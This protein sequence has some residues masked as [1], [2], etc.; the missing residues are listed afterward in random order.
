MSEEEL[1]EIESYIDELPEEEVKE[2]ESAVDD[3]S[4]HG[5]LTPWITMMM[6]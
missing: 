3:L 4:E 1:E 2:I 6:R 5:V